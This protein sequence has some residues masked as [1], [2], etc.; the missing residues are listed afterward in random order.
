MTLFILQGLLN[1][2]KVICPGLPKLKSHRV[3][4]QTQSNHFKVA[5]HS[6]LLGAGQLKSLC[7]CHVSN[8]NEGLGRT[9]LQQQVTESTGPQTWEDSMNSRTLDN[10]RAHASPSEERRRISTSAKYSG[11]HVW[12]PVCRAFSGRRVLR[13]HK[14]SAIIQKFRVPC[15]PGK[16]LCGLDLT[17]TTLSPKYCILTEDNGPWKKCHIQLSDQLVSPRLSI[18]YSSISF[19]HISVRLEVFVFSILFSINF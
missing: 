11:E 14:N 3:K 10:S 4:I 18:T 9:A 7:S 8:T 1:L 17:Y 5:L 13:I 12:G 16:Y 15:M 2:K 19:S 6:S